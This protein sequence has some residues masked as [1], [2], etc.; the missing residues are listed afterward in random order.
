MW[1]TGHGDD[2]KSDM[3]NLLN[4]STFSDFKIVCGDQTFNCHKCIMANKSEVIKTMLMLEDWSEKTLRIKDFDPAT[5]KGVKFS[6][7]IMDH[8]F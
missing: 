1:F 6:M 5:V 8:Y 4:D 3:K 7:I 2:S